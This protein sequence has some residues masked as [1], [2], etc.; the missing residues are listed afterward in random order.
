MLSL[1]ML[2]S[3]FLLLA[4]SLSSLLR[5]TEASHE[6]DWSAQYEAQI[7][8]LKASFQPPDTGKTITLLFTTGKK[9]VGILEALTDQSVT[10]RIDAA[11][12]TYSKAILAQQTRIRL[13]AEDY[14]RFWATK[15]LSHEKAE[16][17]KKKEEER[18]QQLADQPEE[19]EAKVAKPY[20][21]ARKGQEAIAD[22]HSLRIWTSRN[23]STTEAVL[24]KDNGFWIRLRTS[25][26]KKVKVARYSLSDCDIRYLDKVARQS[27]YCQDVVSVICTND[28]C[29][30]HVQ[31]KNGDSRK[32]WRTALRL[33][34][35]Y[36]VKRMKYAMTNWYEVTSVDFSDEGIEAKSIYGGANPFYA[37]YAYGRDSVDLGTLRYVA[38]DEFRL[39]P[40]RDAP[41]AFFRGEMGEIMVNRV[42]I[43]KSGRSGTPGLNILARFA[44]KILIFFP[45]SF[46]EYTSVGIEE[47]TSVALG[48]STPYYKIEITEGGFWV[49]AYMT[50]GDKCVSNIL[51]VRLTKLKRKPHKRLTSDWRRRVDVHD[52]RARWREQE[53]RKAPG[54]YYDQEI[55][56]KYMIVDGKVRTLE[57][58]EGWVHETIDESRV[59]VWPAAIRTYRLATIT[60]EY[61]SSVPDTKCF[62]LGH[63]KILN[64]AVVATLDDE[65]NVKKGDY[66]VMSP[67]VKSGKWETNES[68][69]DPGLL[70]EPGSRSDRRYRL[71]KESKTRKLKEAHRY[72]LAKESKNHKLKEAGPRYE[73]EYDSYRRAEEISYSKY[74]E[75]KKTG[76]KFPHE[77]PKKLKLRIP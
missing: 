13:F 17:Q 12:L 1:K 32:I 19:Q 26:G 37:T 15:R 47:Y 21:K 49:Y 59:M 40:T 24:D 66:L 36:H 55:K 51:K 57:V 77:R 56:G 73:Y 54:G 50:R 29:W 20:G 31:T 11:T 53:I 22:P 8:K 58:L 18:S 48:M 68:R 43:D 63:P 3:V 62:V 61:P 65:R 39:I 28:P 71:A 60:R 70:F 67:V 72:R 9:R 74:L 45:S 7:A 27:L 25:Q 4:I 2:L 6:P 69:F 16:Y 52:K 76:Y 35:Q 5:A 14:A 34:D 10:L 38:G 41:P 23:G 42:R 44:N 30:V 75:L 64:S 46:T 33:E